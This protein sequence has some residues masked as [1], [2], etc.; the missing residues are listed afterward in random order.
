MDGD[1]V[2][3]AEGVPSTLAAVSKA[4]SAGA[5]PDPPAGAGQRMRRNLAAGMAMTTVAQVAVLVLSTITSVALA[6]LLGPSGTGRFALV[7]TLITVLAMVFGFGLRQG[8]IYYVS[9]RR[10]EYRGALGDARRA[11]AVFGCL[12]ALVGFLFYELTS[13]S[14]MEGI[15]RTM[16]LAALVALPFAISLTYSSALALSVERWESFGVITVLAPA[17]VLVLSVSLAIPF[18]ATGA[19]VGLG[20]AQVVAGVG[21]ALLLRR[22]AAQAAAPAVEPQEKLERPLREAIS[23]GSRSWVAILLQFLN[24]RIDLFVLNAYASSASVGVYSVA[25]TVTAVGWLLPDAIQTILL[26][27]TAELSREAERDADQRSVSDESDTRG[28]RHTIILMPGIAALLVLLLVVVVPLFYG[29]EFDDSVELGLL[30]IPGV[31][32]IGLGKVLLTVITGRGFPNYYMYVSLITAPATLGLYL[33]LIPDG[34]ANGAAIASTLSYA[35]T[36][37][38]AVVVFRRVTRLPLRSFLVPRR[39]DFVDYM[40]AGKQLKQ[41]LAAALA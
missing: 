6:R 33:L 10:W 3:A 1:S 34:G 12:G 38:L 41:R 36:T 29:A 7:M 19:I 37:V 21:S 24:Y 20:A 40:H 22:R 18:G 13:G 15:T 14:V 35:L 11:A 28:I 27:R 32:I 16:A 17:A 8:L 30:L 2:A 31:V 39:G 9:G 4:H 23:F 25:V 26:S 5:A